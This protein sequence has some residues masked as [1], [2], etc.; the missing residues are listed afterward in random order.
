MHFPDLMQ[1]QVQSTVAAWVPI[2]LLCKVMFNLYIAQSFIAFHGWKKKSFDFSALRAR[3]SQFLS[4]RR[5]GTRRRRSFA[6]LPRASSI[7]WFLRIIELVFALFLLLFIFRKDISVLHP[8]VHFAQQVV[9][10]LLDVLLIG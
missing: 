7:A 5:R 10:L 8:F 6:L 9:Q 2:A 4:E 3:L 1:L